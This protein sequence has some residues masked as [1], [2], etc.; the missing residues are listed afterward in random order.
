MDDR[1][2][3]VRVSSIA[4]LAEIGLASPSCLAPVFD[5]LMTDSEESVRV[6]AGLALTS[7]SHL[8]ERLSWEVFRAA[9]DPRPDVRRSIAR[10]LATGVLLPAVE[11][12]RVCTLLLRDTDS[13]VRYHAI[14]AI[15]QTATEL[16]RHADALVASLSDPD[17]AVREISART[18][19]LVFQPSGNV[20]AALRRALNDHDA[21]TRQAALQSL[22][23]LDPE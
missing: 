22:R 1:N 6:A 9:D 2:P 16:D 5:K 23:L 7:V 13:I 14:E 18:L 12:E 11:A 19:G 3:H 15:T 17:A 10:L 20:L 21:L 4:A 8:P